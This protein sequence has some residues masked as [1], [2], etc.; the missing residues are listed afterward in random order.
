[1][2]I[3]LFIVILFITLQSFGQ[4]GLKSDIIGNWSYINEQGEKEK[5]IITN[6]SWSSESWIQNNEKDWKLFKF[7]VKY[8][9]IKKNKIRILDKEGGILKIIELSDDTLIIKG[10]WRKSKRLEFS[11]E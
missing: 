5:L 2:K 7:S 10:K 11:K 3:F 9:I 4:D 1:M 8:E 6:D